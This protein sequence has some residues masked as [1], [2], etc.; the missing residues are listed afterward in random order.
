VAAAHDPACPNL[1]VQV[2]WQNACLM[3]T[4]EIKPTALV[5]N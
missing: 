2:G 4:G 3:E 5:A 1:P